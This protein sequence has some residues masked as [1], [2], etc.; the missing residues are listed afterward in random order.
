MAMTPLTDRQ[1]ARAYAA[2]TSCVICEATIGEPCRNRHG[3]KYPSAVHTARKRAVA[4]IRKSAPKA[5]QAM[6]DQVR[7]EGGA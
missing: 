1:R 4:Q 7:S 3:H 5:Y 2:L 6:I